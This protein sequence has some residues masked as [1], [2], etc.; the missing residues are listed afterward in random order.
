MILDI[1]CPKKSYS[2]KSERKN[3]LKKEDDLAES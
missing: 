2:K 1:G 3:G